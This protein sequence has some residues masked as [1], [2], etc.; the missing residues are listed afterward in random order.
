MTRF[1]GAYGDGNWGKCGLLWRIGEINKRKE[2]F[3]AIVQKG[4]EEW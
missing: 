4:R 2:Q 1:G 3:S